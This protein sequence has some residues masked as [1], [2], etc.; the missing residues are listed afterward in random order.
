LKGTPVEEVESFVSSTANH[1]LV[2][3]VEVLEQIKRRGIK[4]GFI[5]ENIQFTSQYLAKKFDADVVC[6][7]EVEV[8][9]NIITGKIKKFSPGKKEMINAIASDLSLDLEEILYVGNEKRVSGFVDY[10]LL[11]PRRRDL[12]KLNS[13]CMLINNLRELS[14]ILYSS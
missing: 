11:N 6:S 12:R 8:K 9:N 2:D 5:S 14:S 10:V 7:N 4:I 1:Y 13:R 3:G